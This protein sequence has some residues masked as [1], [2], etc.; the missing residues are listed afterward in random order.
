[1]GFRGVR[2]S[3]F[4]H[5]YGQPARKEQCYDNIK[6]TRNA[7]DCGF[8]A[9]NPKFIAI[10]TEVA[11]GGSFLVLP[12][13]KYGRLEH[14]NAFKVAGH[15]GAI[16]DIKW[17]PFNDNIIASASDDASVKLWYIPDGG[18]TQNLTE[19]L[20]QL[21]GH[22]RRVGF[23]EWHPT[24]DNILASV[25][26]DYTIVIWHVTKAEVVTVIDCHPDII[27]SLAFN[28]EGSLLATTCKDRKLRIIDPRS[29]KVIQ[30][31]QCH[32]GTK[33]SK[34]IF[35]GDT[36]R[37]LT[38]GFARYSD[39]QFAI[40]DENDLEKPLSCEII[41]SSSG[42]LFPFY[43]HDTRMLYLA[44]KGDGNIRYYEMVDHP[45][46]SYY[47]NQFLSGAPQVLKKLKTKPILH[48]VFTQFASWLLT[49]T[50]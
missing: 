17:N 11:G 30:E 26:F 41:D 48:F 10:V 8:C 18:L 34:V 35:L 14:H 1:M 36:G 31:G 23:I 7:H 50:G 12:L 2:T 46:W 16:L 32:T 19:C 45:P 29:G 6:I 15:A 20:V 28:R 39:R 3:K 5:V 25:G 27:Y 40:W 43:D 44:G 49:L 9:V 13:E 42:V 21:T 24:A 22:K 47:L 4:R 33:A 38:T 37:L